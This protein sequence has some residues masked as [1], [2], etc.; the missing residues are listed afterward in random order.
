MGAVAADLLRTGRWAEV[1]L[2]YTYREDYLQPPPRIFERTDGTFSIKIWSEEAVHLL[3]DPPSDEPVDNNRPFLIQAL[4]CEALNPVLLESDMHPSPE[5]ATLKPRLLTDLDTHFLPYVPCQSTSRRPQTKVYIPS[6]PPSRT[7]PMVRG[8]WVRLYG[9]LRTKIGRGVLSALFVLG[10][11]KSEK[12]AVAV[13]E[14]RV[15]EQVGEDF[16]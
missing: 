14:N 9:N 5:F 11:A 6:I 12:E 10:D 4:Y 3:V 2:V 7:N 15:E 13:N 8:Q 1:A 16:G